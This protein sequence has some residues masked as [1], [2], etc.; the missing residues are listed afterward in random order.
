MEK[1]ENQRTKKVGRPRSFDRAKALTLALDVF[2]KKG[3]ASASISELCNYMGI[4]PPSLYAAFGSKSALFLETIKLYK[5]VYWDVAYRNLDK[6][7]DVY[8]AFSV[9]LNDALTTLSQPKG[10]SG[11]M[12][13]LTSI[14]ISSDSLEIID[15]LRLIRKNSINLIHNRLLKAIADQQIL[16]DTDVKALAYTMYALLEGMA[17]AAKSNGEISPE[18]RSIAD[19]AMTLLP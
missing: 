1:L 4:N 13:I 8:R 16:A 19:T 7:P 15:E 5:K 14:N 2:W 12:L 17:V 6:E 18:L 9:F 3:Y 10:K 11:C